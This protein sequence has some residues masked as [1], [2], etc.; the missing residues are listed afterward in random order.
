MWRTFFKIWSCWKMIS[1]GVGFARSLATSVPLLTEFDDL[2]PA[3][4]RR[5]STVG[6]DAGANI[7]WANDW[8]KSRLLVVTTV[9][10]VIP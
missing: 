8:I 2:S 5:G 9:I 6:N 1:D 10:L 7:V 4:D 3:G